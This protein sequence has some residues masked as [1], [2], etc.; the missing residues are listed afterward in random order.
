VIPG[1]LD[2]GEARDAFANDS[3]GSADPHAPAA[4]GERMRPHHPSSRELSGC[5]DGARRR[6]FEECRSA[7]RSRISTKSVWRRGESVRRRHIS[8]G[9]SNTH[10][11]G[12]EEATDATDHQSRNPPFHASPVGTLLLAG[13]ASMGSASMGSADRQ[14]CDVRL[15]DDAENRHGATGATPHATSLDRYRA[16]T[17]CARMWTLVA[18]A[19]CEPSPGRLAEPSE[20]MAELLIETRRR[21]VEVARELGSDDPRVREVVVRLA[22]LERSLEEVRLESVSGHK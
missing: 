9:D 13:A 12:L 6:T 21:W 20:C 7:A 19:E 10:Q 18:E 15:P 5:G 1:A 14:P 3:A 17:E 22:E 4:P 11:C 8:G 2:G 16:M